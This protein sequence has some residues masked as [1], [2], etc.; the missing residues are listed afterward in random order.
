MY[1]SKVIHRA[2]DWYMT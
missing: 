1:V 2:E